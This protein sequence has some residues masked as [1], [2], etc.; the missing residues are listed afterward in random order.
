MDLAVAHNLRLLCGRC[1]GIHSE[2]VLVSESVCGAGRC[3]WPAGT[4][5]GVWVVVAE[6]QRSHRG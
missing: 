5:F 4:R 2:W 3:G 6:Q 1:A